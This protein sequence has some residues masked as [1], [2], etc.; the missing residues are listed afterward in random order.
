MIKRGFKFAFLR[1]LYRM[2]RYRTFTFSIV[3]IPILSFLLLTTLLSRGVPDAIPIAVLDEDNTSMSRMASEMVSASRFSKIE[4]DI[5]SITEG[6]ALMNQGKIQAILVFPRDMERS[7]MRG[8]QVQVP[9]FV[10]GVNLL[11]SSLV[12]KDVIYTMQT[13]STGIEIQKL[14]TKG[15]PENE[16]YGLALPINYDKHILFDPYI[17][18]AYYLLPGFMPMMLLMFTILSTIFA[19]GIELKKNTSKL[20]IS[21]AGGSV[22]KALTAKLLPYTIIMS[23]LGLLMNVIMFRTVGIPLNGSVWLI[24]VGTFL[25]ILAYQA[26]GVVLITILA[27]LRLALSIGAGYSVLAF[28]FSGLT[29]PAIAMGELPRLLTHLFPFTPYVD[30][31]IDQAMRGAPVVVS[32]PY[33]LILMVFI[34]LP[35]LLLPRL[36]KIATNSKYS[37]K[38]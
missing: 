15:I 3:V 36:K 13:F 20:W 14:V 7:V 10:N 23:L 27:N 18:Y 16:A 4:Y 2:G 8:E 38:I 26:M 30:L 32:L 6:R 17:N 1:E 29:F 31:F 19:I 24:A 5:A 28:T 12:Q 25:F 35:I 33:L 37:G 9:L 21:A 22:V 11:M 34:L